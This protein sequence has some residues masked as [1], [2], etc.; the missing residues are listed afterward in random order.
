MCT[1]IRCSALQNVY[2]IGIHEREETCK[3][4]RRNFTCAHVEN[5]FAATV[6]QY[7]KYFQ[8]DDSTVNMQ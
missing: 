1:L 5:S 6:S 3:L 2:R 7:L 8:P 4:R